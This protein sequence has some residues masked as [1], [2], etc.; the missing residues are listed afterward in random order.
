MKKLDIIKKLLAKAD[1]GSLDLYTPENVMVSF[2]GSKPGPVA[3]L[4][5][6]DWKMVDMVIKRGDIGLGEAYHEG[7]F[8]S[9]DLM[10]FLNYC[11]RNVDSIENRGNGSFLNNMIF[12]FYDQF[13]RLNT[14]Y[15]SKKNIVKHYDIGNDFYKLWLDPTMTYSSA[16]RKNDNENLQ[17]AQI[18]KYQRIID[19]LDIKNKSVLEIGCGWGGFA[20]EA[21]KSGA[22]ITGITISDQQ[23]HFAKDKLGNNAK[24]LMQDYRD[25]TSKYDRIVSIE[26]FEAVGEKYWPIYFNQIKNSLVKG[27]RAMI[28]AITIDDNVFDRYRKT[29]DYIRHHVFPGGMLASKERFALEVQKAKLDLVEVFEFGQDYAWTL[30]EWHKNFM[31]QKALLLSMHYS[32]VFLRAWEF[33]LSICVAG[34]ESH[35]TNVMQVEIIN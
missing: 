33:Y 18:N 28:Q 31:A 30:R 17:E 22:D 3:D 1:I 20:N 19:N 35:R 25:V 10:S 16:L 12:Y 13:L 9:S 27:G 6:K 29:S 4:H 32:P 7:L 11:T 34:F 21:I 15:G 24:I 23:Y 5:I 2:K 14:K 8:E 26:M